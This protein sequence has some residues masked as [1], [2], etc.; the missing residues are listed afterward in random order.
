MLKDIVAVCPLT[1]YNLRLTFED[2]IEGIVNIANLIEF[3]GIFEPLV[4]PTYFA[5]VAVNPDLG[6]ISWPNGADLDPDVL[7]SVVTDQPLPSY[8][9]LSHR[10]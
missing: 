2:D 5:Q 4:N 6:T 7:Y 1:D 8:T 9:I 10:R 3:T